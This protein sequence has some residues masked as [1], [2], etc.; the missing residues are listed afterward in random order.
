[1]TE[2]DNA[3]TRVNPREIELSDALQ[4]WREGILRNALSQI[5]EA[6]TQFER[7]SFPTACFLAMTAIEE[8]GKLALQVVTADWARRR[9]GVGQPSEEWV[10]RVQRYVRSHPEKARQAAVWSLMINSGADRR[11][12]IHPISGMTRTS[13]VILLVRSGR[14]M[15]LRNTRLYVDLH[16][17]RLHVVSPVEAIT[18][19]HAFYMACMAHE[20]VAQQATAAFEDLPEGP[21]VEATVLSELQEFMG[22]A[23]SSVD[24][25]SLDFLADP[26]PLREEAE[27]RE[28]EGSG[29]SR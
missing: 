18:P 23:G 13:G 8:A 14:W 4:A 6:R 29:E 22:Q 11:Q 28:T 16:V 12:G 21:S 3:P 10:R 17:N 2:G 7:R 9:I 19:A 26:Q 25:D 15:S 27:R 1:M 24:V 20:V 5:R